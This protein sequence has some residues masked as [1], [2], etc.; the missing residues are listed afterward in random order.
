MLGLSFYLMV[1]AATAVRAPEMFPNSEPTSPPSG[2]AP[3]YEANLVLVG[4]AHT[5]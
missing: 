5:A 3:D 1:I 4:H 2:C